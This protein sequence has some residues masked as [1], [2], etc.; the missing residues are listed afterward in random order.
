VTSIAPRGLYLDALEARAGIV[1]G[2]VRIVPVATET[3]RAM[4]GMGSFVPGI[5]RMAG[6]TW[7][8]EDLSVAVGAITNPEADGGYSPLYVLA[9]SLCLCVAAAAG[10]DAND[11]LHVDFRDAEGLARRPTDVPPRQRR[12]VQESRTTKRLS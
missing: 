4:L 2:D 11:T 5:P 7:G 9:N 6:V 8:A 12:R 10:V 3:A 1:P